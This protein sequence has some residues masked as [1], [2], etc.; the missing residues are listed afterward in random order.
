M[1]RVEVAVQETIGASVGV[2]SDNRHESKDGVGMESVGDMPV[3]EWSWR[4]IL[5]AYL[6]RRLRHQS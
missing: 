2:A 6:P 4:Q 5:T 3:L 1:I